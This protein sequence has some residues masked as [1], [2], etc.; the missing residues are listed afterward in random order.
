M[1][2]FSR[3]KQ[4]LAEVMGDSHDCAEGRLAFDCRHRLDRKARGNARRLMDR[5]LLA[6]TH[7]HNLRATIVPT[8]TAP[9]TEPPTPHHHSPT[10][11]LEI[12]PQNKERIR[13]GYI[14]TTALVCSRVS[15]RAGTDPLL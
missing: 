11:P 6:D 13:P 4:F 12:R 5:S 2:P 9:Q 10:V 3:S 1:K 14:L 8:A 7:K 15:L